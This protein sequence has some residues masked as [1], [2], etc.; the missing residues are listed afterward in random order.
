MA[1]RI[2]VAT[3]ISTYIVGFALSM[4]LL[5]W[6]DSAH[7]PSK[8]MLALMTLYGFGLSKCLSTVNSIEGGIC[9]FM[10][11]VLLGV[12]APPLEHWKPG[13]PINSVYM[14]TIISFVISRVLYR[15]DRMT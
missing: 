13:F 15:L 7:N 3:V 1:N 5:V 2:R 8:V 9:V 4:V 10:L 6:I 14:V 12:S 11:C